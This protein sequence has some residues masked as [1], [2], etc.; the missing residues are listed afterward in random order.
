MGSGGEAAGPL[1]TPMTKRK[2][3]SPDYQVPLHS[4]GRAERPH[5]PSRWH[6]LFSIFLPFSLGGCRPLLQVLHGAP[7]SIHVYAVRELLQASLVGKLQDVCPLSTVSWVSPIAIGHPLIEHRAVVHACREVVR[8]PNN[9]VPL[10]LQSGDIRVAHVPAPV[11][12]GVDA[13]RLA[14]NRIL[15]G[16]QKKEHI[17]KRRMLCR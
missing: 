7:R 10:Q 4:T 14:R 15:E 17:I 5:G 6:V 13:K 11:E 8:I 12:A 2:C 1:L 16:A 9:R 3:R